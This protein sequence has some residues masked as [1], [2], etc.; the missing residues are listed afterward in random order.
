M[1]VPEEDHEALL[2]ANHV[3]VEDDVRLGTIELPVLLQRHLLL[4]EI[5]NHP[6]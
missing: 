2:E 3:R 4:L 1:N 5:S 6:N